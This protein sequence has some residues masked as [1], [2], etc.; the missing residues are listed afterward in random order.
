MAGPGCLPQLGDPYIDVSLFL[1]Q[2]IETD[3]ENST[4][5]VF[6][7]GSNHPI[8]RGPGLQHSHLLHGRFIFGQFGIDGILSGLWMRFDC[9]VRCVCKTKVHKKSLV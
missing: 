7:D 6:D 1:C 8:F 9:L 3:F 2:D 5:Q 4:S